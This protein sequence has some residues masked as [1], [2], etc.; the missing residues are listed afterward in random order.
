[1]SLLELVSSSERN[2]AAAVSPVTAVVVS[3]ATRQPDTCVPVYVG[4][5][6]Q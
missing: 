5:L 3:D 6:T 2:R 4:K 1:M